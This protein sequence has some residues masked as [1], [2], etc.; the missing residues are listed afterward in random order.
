MHLID[1][2]K[3]LVQK[4]CIIR[5]FW[6]QSDL[7]EL[8]IKEYCPIVSISGFFH[9][10]LIF[11]PENSYGSKS[12]KVRNMIEDKYKQSALEL[13]QNQKFKI[14]LDLPSNVYIK[15]LDPSVIQ[16]ARYIEETGL[17]NFDN[18]ENTEFEMDKKSINFLY[19]DLG[20]FSIVLERKCFFPYISWYLRCV[21]VETE[22]C[23]AILDLK[24]KF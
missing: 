5:I 13:I 4:S 2:P 14:K 1:I 15:D 3:I 17:W 16:V 7:R 23:R 11:H 20:I 19:N 24:S 12:W 9:S 6:V 21:E 8:Q 22:N 10:D 18:F